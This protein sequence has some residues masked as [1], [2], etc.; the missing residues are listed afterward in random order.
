LPLLAP[1]EHTAIED[2]DVHE[3]WVALY[4]R[5]RGVKRVRVLRTRPADEP[6]TA[7]PTLSDEQ[8][9]PLHN[10]S[11]PN[12]SLP[13][14]SLPN[15]SAPCAVTAGANRQFATDAIHFTLSSPTMPP[16]P[17][18]YDM[19]TRALTAR[20]RM[21]ARECLKHDSNQAIHRCAEGYR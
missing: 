21:D 12:G 13:T 15:G 19:V 4:E 18:A 2:V 11:L 3:R 8:I 17:Y 1:S 14:G 7:P 5:H 10:G 20:S 6:A 9:V 16:T